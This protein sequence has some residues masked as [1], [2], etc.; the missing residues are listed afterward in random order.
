MNMFGTFERVW[1]GGA[2]PR[3][4]GRLHGL[5]SSEPVSVLIE[6]TSGNK[7][8]RP[9]EFEMLY[10]V[11]YRA[12]L[13]QF[14]PVECRG[15]V[16]Y[17]DDNAFIASHLPIG[18][19]PVERDERWVEIDDPNEVALNTRGTLV[20]TTGFEILPGSAKVS[21]FDMNLIEPVERQEG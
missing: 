20:T 16:D 14:R 8:W 11:D 17:L 1:N 5:R 12:W 7:V 3:T 21:D 2:I 10:E 9:T 19:I 15:L 18:Q 4:P 13:G 6:D